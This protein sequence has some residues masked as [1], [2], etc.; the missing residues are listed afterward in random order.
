MSYSII[1]VLSIV[2]A[3]TVS[4]SIELVRCNLN[5]GKEK[6][7]VFHRK[8]AINFNNIDEEEFFNN[9]S[10]IFLSDDEVSDI[11]NI[12]NEIRVPP[13]A[14]SSV[15]LDGCSYSICFFDDD[16]SAQSSFR[17]W[18]NIPNEWQDL[19]RIVNI[20]SKYFQ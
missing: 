4:Y 3:F 10:K 17:W 1:V 13:I 19:D 18:G 8:P 7:Y 9:V 12:I 14:Q 20:L 15:G 2:P 5:D 11:I 6:Y 16:G